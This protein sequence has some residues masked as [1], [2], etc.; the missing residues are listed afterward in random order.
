MGQVVKSQILS[1]DLV[2]R[3]FNT[4][5]GLGKDETA[6]V[7]DGYAEKLLRSGHNN[8]KVLQIIT[9]GIRGYERR[10]RRCLREGRSIYR[11]NL[12]SL[13]NRQRKKVMGASSWFK[14]RKR[15]LEDDEEE[16]RGV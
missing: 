12:E 1:N 6:R 2:R 5:D 15:K 14:T 3:L 13:G 4:G 7:V 16:Q 10:V 8:K 11:T 9:A